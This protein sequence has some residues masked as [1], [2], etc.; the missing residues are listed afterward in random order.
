MSTRRYTVADDKSIPEDAKSYAATVDGRVYW[1]KRNE[2]GQ[3]VRHDGSNCST[4]RAQH[5]A[6]RAYLESRLNQADTETQ[7]H[8]LNAKGI[9]RGTS[10]ARIILHGGWQAHASGELVEWLE[11]NGKTLKFSQ[12][13]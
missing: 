4:K 13:A 11:K 3:F 8:L 10:S 7:G 12:F 2:L 1:N 6:Y 5:D 9:R